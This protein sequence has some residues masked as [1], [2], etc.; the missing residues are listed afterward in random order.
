[1]RS[2]QS[3]DGVFLYR[4][5]VDMRR[6]LDGLSE[7]IRHGM[8]KPLDGKL[9]FV[10]VGKA[11]NRIKILYWDR[12]GYALWYKRLERGRFPWPK[13]GSLA[14]DISPNLLEFLLEGVDIFI[15][16]HESVTIETKW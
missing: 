7:I 13:M 15:K 3:F 10:F 12:T 8:E 6:S 5:A 9:L 11:R 2:I 14:F 4:D 1:M 16:P